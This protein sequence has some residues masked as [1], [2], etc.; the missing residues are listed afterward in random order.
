MCFHFS[1]HHG[2][3]APQLTQDK[4]MCSVISAVLT[5]QS[6]GTSYYVLAAFKA[7]RSPAKLLGQ[8][9]EGQEQGRSE[10]GISRWITQCERGNQRISFPLVPLCLLIQEL[11]CS[12]VALVDKAEICKPCAHGDQ[13]DTPVTQGLQTCQHSQSMLHR[14]SLNTFKKHLFKKD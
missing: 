8:R 5:L 7:F 14:R 11:Q 3:F 4:E 9:V 1:A 13:Q 12:T 10:N 6:T 2:L